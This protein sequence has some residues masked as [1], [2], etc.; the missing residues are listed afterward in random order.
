MS[1]RIDNIEARLAAPE[2]KL[3]AVRAAVEET[4]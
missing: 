1:D 3:A 2:T 4:R